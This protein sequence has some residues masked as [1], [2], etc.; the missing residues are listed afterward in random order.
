ML[1][2]GH[3]KLTQI[4]RIHQ[5]DKCSIQLK[6]TVANVFAQ[7]LRHLNATLLRHVNKQFS[8]YSAYPQTLLSGK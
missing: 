4:L 3:L 5:T 7:T 8:R 6:E 1:R 2:R